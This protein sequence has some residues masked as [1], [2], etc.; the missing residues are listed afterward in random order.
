MT[1][2]EPYE[3]D[4]GG[5]MIGSDWNS[6][7]RVGPATRVW[8]GTKP[9]IGEVLLRLGNSRIYGPLTEM[10]RVGRAIVWGVR[11]LHGHLAELEAD[12]TA[13]DLP[14]QCGTCNG[15]HTL[16]EPHLRAGADALRA[17]A[18]RAMGQHAFAG[19]PPLPRVLVDAAA[20]F[21]ADD[22]PT[23]ARLILHTFATD[24]V[25]WHVIGVLQQ[26]RERGELWAARPALPAAGPLEL[27]H[28][29]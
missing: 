22:R 23:E 9:D 16:T 25:A 11:R 3:Q 20:Y 27:P 26:L 2:D 8:V 15:V 21:V 28:R 4:F 13:P 19:P 14:T 7:L 5:S 10:E 6:E 18:Y 24:E 29:A 17:E 12:A 1:E